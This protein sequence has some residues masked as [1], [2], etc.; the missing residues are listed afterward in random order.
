MQKQMTYGFT[1]SPLGEAA[2][3][4]SRKLWLAGLG[5]TVVTRDWLES[6]G[7]HMFRTLVKQGTARRIARDPFRGR[8]RRNVVHPGEH[9]V[10]KDPPHRRSDG[11]RRGELD[12]RLRPAGAAEVAAEARAAEGFRPDRQ[13]EGSG[14]ARAQDGEDPCGSRREEGKAHDE[15]RVTR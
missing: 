12:G 3:V 5:A 9:D 14:E 13:G 1:S 7:G 11:E 15:A 2:L 4:A 10:E 8:P 6:E